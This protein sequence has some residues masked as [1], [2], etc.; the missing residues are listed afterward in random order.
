MRILHYAYVSTSIR[1]KIGNMTPTVAYDSMVKLL[2]L[3]HI[4]LHSIEHLS[5]A[6]DAVE[7]S[8]L[9]LTHKC[10]YI[11][12]YIELESSLFF[13]HDKDAKMS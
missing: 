12:I 7:I 6:G 2:L 9:V 10:T 3:Y 5:V 13:Q 11:Y 1:P 4:T 8:P